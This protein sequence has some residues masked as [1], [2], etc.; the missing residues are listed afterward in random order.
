MEGSFM[1]SNLVRGTA[2]LTIGLFLSKVLGLLYIIPLYQIVGEEGIGLY[3]YAYIPYNLALAVAVSGAPL[4]ISKFVSKYNALG[5]YATGRKLMKSGV[6]IMSI[7]GFIGFLA[8]YFLATPLAEIVNPDKEQVEEIASV[9]RAVSFAVLVVPLLSIS[10]GYLQGY[11][12]FEPT[13]VSQF[14]EQLVRVIFV[15]VGSYIAVSWFNAPTNKAVNFAVFAAFIGAIAGLLVLWKYFREYKDEF[16]YL[17]SKSPPA[18]SIPLKDIYREVITYTLPFVLVGTINPLY[19]FVDMIT[20]SNAMSSIGIP[21]KDIKV[22][23]GILNTLTHK[24]VMIPVMVATG[25]SMALISIITAYYTK[26][27]HKGINRSLDQT[28]QILLFLTIPM[29]SGLILLSNEFYQLLYEQNPV[30]SAIL[31]SYAPVAILFA[32]FTVTAAILQGID[33][34]KW[35]VLTSLLGL[36]IK[37]IVNIPLIKMF[38]TNGSIMATALGYSVAVGLNLLIIA[39]TMNYQSKVVFRRIVLIGIFN[40]AMVI[41]VY[42]TLQ[43]LYAIKPAEGRFISFVYI[44]VCVFIGATVYGILAFKSGL[45]QKLF[46]DRLTTILQK[47]GIGR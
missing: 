7:T 5:D 8:L 24:F 32:L 15:V 4:A 13:S 42:F 27:D 9:I 35:I 1:A 22:Y 29:V 6:I 21:G 46:G 41:A 36:L 3:N 34:H 16:D 23:F 10:R 39:K 25:F 44:L 19:Q 37:M 11:Q 28:Y 14:I 40:I 12:K 30:G 2:I 43:G 31:A 38:E 47:V 33:R 26:N 18:Q 17:L 20:F 45:A